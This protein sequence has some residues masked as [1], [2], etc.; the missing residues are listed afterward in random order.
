M[1]GDDSCLVVA[2]CKAVSMSK[3]CISDLADDHM[4]G[5]MTVSCCCHMNRVDLFCVCTARDPCHGIVHINVTSF[6]SI[7]E[8]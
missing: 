8:H 1:D 3:A 2:V 6:S 5:N 7:L 4:M